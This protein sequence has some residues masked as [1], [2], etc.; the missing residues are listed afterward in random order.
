MRVF[1]ETYA[2]DGAPRSARRATLA[3]ASQPS[4]RRAHP[5]QIGFLYI[6]PCQSVWLTQT[7]SQRLGGGLMI[8]N[9]RGVQNWLSVSPSN[10]HAAKTEDQA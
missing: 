7:E 2:R 8:R 1:S 10:L 5:G 9:L 3:R 4:Q 6:F